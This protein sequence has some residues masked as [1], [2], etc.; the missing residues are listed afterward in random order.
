MKT[1]LKTL[2]AIMLLSSP[3][4]HTAN[5][6]DGV[7]NFNG[8]IINDACE[9]DDA[10]KNMFVD[11]GMVSATSFSSTGDKASPTAFEIKLKNCP[12]TLKQVATK[13]DG[14]IDDVNSDLLKVL[15]IDSFPDAAAKDIGI[16]IAEEDGTPIPLHTASKY[17]KI[18]SG[19]ASLPFVARYVSTADK[20]T[21][22]QALGT[23]QFTINYQ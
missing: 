13:F 9:V 19:S 20:V 4:Y 21:P 18:S 11:L 17:R 3:L 7:V 1:K 15:Q 12:K 16:E 5:A 14:D 2:A 8:S 22:G 10:S 6:S 23:T